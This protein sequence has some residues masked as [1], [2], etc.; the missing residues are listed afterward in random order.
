[1]DNNFP[2]IM[3]EEEEHILKSYPAG[4]TAHPDWYIYEYGNHRKVLVEVNHET[5]KVHFLREL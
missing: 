4:D 3:Q 5:G 2:E 1:M